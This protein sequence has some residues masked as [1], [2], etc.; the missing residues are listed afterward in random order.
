MEY[1]DP[2]LGFGETHMF[3]KDERSPAKLN[4]QTQCL[5]YSSKKYVIL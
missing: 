3:I 2:V 5:A 4:H 1:V